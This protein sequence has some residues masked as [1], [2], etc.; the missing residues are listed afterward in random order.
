MTLLVCVTV[1]CLT[2]GYE[3]AMVLEFLILRLAALPAHHFR[4]CAAH[5]R[6]AE[7]HIITSEEGLTEHSDVFRCTRDLML[8]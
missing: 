7:Q 5:S 1:L 6:H 3:A 8:R 2:F 4:W